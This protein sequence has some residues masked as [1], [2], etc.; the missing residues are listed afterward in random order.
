MYKLK[1]SSYPQTVVGGGKIL[2]LNIMKFYGI[3]LVILG[4]VAFC[5]TSMGAVP[6]AVPSDFMCIIKD[7]IYSFHMP[8]FVFVSGCVFAFQVEIRKKEYTLPSLI[9]NKLKRLLL[10]Y[11]V[12]AYLWVLP[13]M[14]YLGKEPLQYAKGLLVG[15]DSRH[16]WYVMMLF[17]VFI[18]FYVL[19]LLC[20][21]F[22]IPHYVILVVAILLYII[23]CTV[24]YFQIDNIFRYLLWFSAGYFLFLNR[25][26][27]RYTL[28]STCILSGIMFMA[29]V[30]VLDSLLMLSNGFIGICIF[31]YISLHSKQ[32]LKSRIFQV[33]SKDSFG[34]YLFHAMI[35][36]IT[37]KLFQP[38]E[39]EPAI[40]SIIVFLTA[41][42][43]SIFLTEVVRLCKLE[44]IIGE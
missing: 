19:R 24:V 41:L 17:G 42:V 37:E 36:Y 30:E 12:F 18:L 13:T 4:H 16:L 40:L 43:L 32:L 23:P 1:K 11:Y 35:I 10:P 2:E 44:I 22:R 9:K 39:V 8:M 5:Y 28:V 27:I 7:V 31:Y 26:W 20:N 38:Y 6:P 33:I 15:I 25:R 21:R 14:F 34:I 29:R 3:L